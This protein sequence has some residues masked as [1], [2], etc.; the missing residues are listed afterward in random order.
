M[1]TWYDDCQDGYP[2]WR[3]T[4]QGYRTYCSIPES[5][6][7][8]DIEKAVTHDLVRLGVRVIAKQLGV[9]RRTVFLRAHKLGYRPVG[10]TGHWVA[11][12][13]AA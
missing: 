6:E 13:E 3:I 4:G 8:K 5:Y 10:K 7:I 1:T 11:P 2:W 12:K 9:T